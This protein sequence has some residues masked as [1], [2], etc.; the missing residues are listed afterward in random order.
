LSSQEFTAGTQTLTLGIAVYGTG[1]VLP[2]GDKAING[3]IARVSLRNASTGAVVAN[4]W[5]MPAP[6]LKPG[7]D[8]SFGVFREI[9][10]DTRAYAGT[11][12]YLEAEFL[13]PRF[14]LL[15]VD[16]YILQTSMGGPE[17]LAKKPGG[18]AEKQIPIAY[19]LHQNYPNPFNPETVLRFDLPEPQTVSLTVFNV[20]G[21]EVFAFDEGRL[22]AGTHTRLVDLRDRPSGTYLYQLVAGPY[23]HT[24]RMV[25]V[26]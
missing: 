8:S 25:F 12:L 10:T 9:T 24:K 5:D 15:L 4:L 22:P 20:L 18:S 21:E 19:A 1:I 2:Y 26:K 16:D 6:A 13:N 3:S 14:P 7:K 23:V 11:S 17:P